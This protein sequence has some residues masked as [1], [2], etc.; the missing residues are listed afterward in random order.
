LSSGLAHPLLLA[1]LAHELARRAGI[2]SAVARYGNS[3]WTALISDDA[4]L[5]IGF[6]PPAPLAAQELRACCAHHIAREML[7]AIAA[8]APAAQARRADQ[9]R[10]AVRPV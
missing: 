8:T 3:F 5:P 1:T 9:L 7:S 4:Y 10:L 6:G 2:R